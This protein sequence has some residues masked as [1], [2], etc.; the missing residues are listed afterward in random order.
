MAQILR[1]W[2]A[3]KHFLQNFFVSH[4]KLTGKVF[5]GQYASSGH[6]SKL[7]LKPCAQY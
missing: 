3:Q 6:Q 5:L 2:D 7:A 4:C 1:G